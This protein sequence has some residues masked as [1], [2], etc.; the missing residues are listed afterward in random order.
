MHKETHI[1]TQ[2][3]TYTEA[4]IDTESHTEYSQGD[5]EST[6]ASVAPH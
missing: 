5:A 2:S 1:H 6:Q 3:H 4:Y